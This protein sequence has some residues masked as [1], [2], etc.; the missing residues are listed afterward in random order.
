MPKTGRRV[1]LAE[2]K[3]SRVREDGIKGMEETIRVRQWGKHYGEREDCLT[4]L[5]R[6]SEAGSRA[7]MELISGVW[8]GPRMQIGW[9]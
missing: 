2:M 6:I 8:R 5:R 3:V 1:S 7:I 9:S 4:D